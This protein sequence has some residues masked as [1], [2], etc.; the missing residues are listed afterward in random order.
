[1][2]INAG[3]HDR[4]VHAITQYDIGQSTRKGYNH[5]A[6]AQY[7]AALEEAE[8]QIHKGNDPIRSFDEVFNEPV[9]SIALDAYIGR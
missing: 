7:L 5:Y 2:A 1:M 6:L 9:L 4:A 3:S 8:K